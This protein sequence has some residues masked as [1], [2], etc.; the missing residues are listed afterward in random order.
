[1]VWSIGFLITKFKDGRRILWGRKNGE[2]LADAPVKT[3]FLVL[4]DYEEYRFNA[5]VTALVIY[6]DFVRR[7]HII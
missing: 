6:D 7:V 1:M 3:L 5:C 2:L 4:N